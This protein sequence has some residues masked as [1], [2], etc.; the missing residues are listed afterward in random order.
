MDNKIII[1]KSKLIKSLNFSE[2]NRLILGTSGEGQSI[3]WKREMIMDEYANIGAATI[4]DNDKWIVINSDSNELTFVSKDEND[5]ELVICKNVCLKKDGEDTH[6]LLIFQKS[7]ELLSKARKYIKSNNDRFY[8]LALNLLPGVKEQINQESDGEV[9]QLINKILQVKSEEEL[10]LYDRMTARLIQS[11]ILYFLETG[12]NDGLAIRIL[13]TLL[14]KDVDT[15]NLSFIGFK[16]DS[17]AVKQWN[18]LTE[19]LDRHMLKSIWDDATKYALEYMIKNVMK[20]EQYNT[21]KEHTV[22]Y[23]T[24][25]GMSS[26]LYMWLCTIMTMDKFIQAWED[27]PNYFE[28]HEYIRERFSKRKKS[29]P[30]SCFLK[31]ENIRIDYIVFADQMKNADRYVSEKTVN[32]LVKDMKDTIL[33][34]LLDDWVIWKV[35]DFENYKGV[36][37][38]RYSCKKIGFSKYIASIRKENLQEKQKR[39]ANMISIKEEKKIRESADTFNQYV[40]CEDTLLIRASVPFPYMR[41]YVHELKQHEMIVEAKPDL[42]NSLYYMDIY[43]KTKKD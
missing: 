19:T 11:I 14:I 1:S 36:A 13:G 35:Y 5:T 9:Q 40:G 38:A 43:I 17:E 33:E 3:H 4:S 22:L 42:F 2:P 41:Y 37:N 7:G 30:L 21:S 8:D 31:A 29:D 24:G 27:C 12:R 20:L 39:I 23:I 25:S 16:N 26:D 18:V 15:M 32:K 28:Y 6:V 10:S 34:D